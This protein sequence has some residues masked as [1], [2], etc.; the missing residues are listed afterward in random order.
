MRLVMN[1]TLFDKPAQS[2][3]HTLIA[4][5]QARPQSIDGERFRSR[6]QKIH[7][8]GFQGVLR[9]SGLTLVCSGDLEMRA[10]GI[11][12]HE[13][14]GD[15]TECGCGA[16][17]REGRRPACSTTVPRRWHPPRSPR[18]RPRRRFRFEGCR[19]CW[20]RIQIPGPLST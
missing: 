2:L 4:D 5:L 6:G 20:C 11:G 13:F 18:G 8:P 7:Y 3:D 12:L 19:S 16:V 17:L 14:K 1:H 10:D 15:G 9:R